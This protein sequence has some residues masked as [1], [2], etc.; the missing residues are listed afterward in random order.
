MK[1]LIYGSKITQTKYARKVAMRL[2]VMQSIK[3][4][5]LMKSRLQCSWLIIQF[6]LNPL[7]VRQMRKNNPSIILLLIFHTRNPLFQRNLEEARVLAD[8]ITERINNGLKENGIKDE[9]S[10][11]PYAIYY[12]YYEQYITIIDE[13]LVQIGICLIPV[14]LYTF[15][16]LGFDV[17]S[18]I[19]VLLTVGLII[20]NTYGMCAIWEVDFNPLTLIN[21]IAAIGLAMEFSGHTVRYFS[22]A[23]KL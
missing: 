4:R 20:M 21:L 17:I 19:I 12:P 7:N 10:V 3:T 5:D 1:I 8:N 6:V 18:G 16:F 15:I 14:F 23:E 2:T 22:Q 13:A 9:V 11:W